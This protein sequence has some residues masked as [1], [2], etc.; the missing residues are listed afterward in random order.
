MV[1]FT[2]FINSRTQSR[3]SRMATSWW[4]VFRMSYLGWV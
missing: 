4:W 2:D 3:C 1:T